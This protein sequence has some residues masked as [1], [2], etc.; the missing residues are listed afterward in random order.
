MPRP[1]KPAK[2]LE[3]SGAFKKN[4]QRRRAREAELRVSSGLGAPPREWVE[5]KE[6]N[7]RCRDLIE[8]WDQIIAQDILGV[9]NVSHRMLVEN[10]CYLMWKIRRANAGYG[11]ATSGDSAQLKANLAAMG[12]TPIDSQ[13]VAEAVRIPQRDDGG[14]RKSPSGSWG[15]LVG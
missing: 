5:S 1:R 11:K 13:R 8:L 7:G 10:T 14:P 15:E 4:P 2:V 6:H 3:L 12:Q 9:L